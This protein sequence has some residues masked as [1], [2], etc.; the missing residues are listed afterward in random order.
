MKLPSRVEV[1]GYLWRVADSYC[2]GKRY[3]QSLVEPTPKLKKMKSE[4]RQIIAILE[5]KENDKCG[6]LI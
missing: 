2:V 1:N 3:G 4:R 5:A 6:R